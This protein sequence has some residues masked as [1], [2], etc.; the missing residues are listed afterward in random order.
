MQHR[1]TVAGQG[2]P[3]EGKARP[4]FDPGGIVVL[5]LRP[6]ET[7]VGQQTSQALRQYILNFQLKPGQRLVERPFIERLGVSRTTLREAIRELAAEGLLTVVAQKGPR[8][9]AHSLEEAT[10]LYEV[11]SALEGLLVIRFVERA[12]NSEIRSLRTASLIFGDSVQ[13]GQGTEGNSVRAATGT[14]SGTKCS[15]WTQSSSPRTERAQAPHRQRH[16][17][18]HANPGDPQG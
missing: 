4:V 12:A 9:S 16:C 1:R 15:N 14:V 13:V 17:L 2:L 3:D 8:V 7:S 5:C 11:R 6:I 10:D 18:R